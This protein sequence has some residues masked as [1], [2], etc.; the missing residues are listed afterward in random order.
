LVDARLPDRWLLNATLRDLS[1]TEW[2][3]FTG[4]LML[5]NNQLTDGLIRNNALALTHPLGLQPECYE[6]L[7][8][9]GL[10]VKVEG[11]YQVVEWEETQTL[12]ATFESQKQNNR[13]RQ[14]IKRERDAAKLNPNRAPLVTRDVTRDVQGDA[15]KGKDRQRE[16]ESSPIARPTQGR[17]Y[18]NYEVRIDPATGEEFE[19]F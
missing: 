19:V 10:W 15:R 2:R 3:V 18:P 16:E 1:D 12:K 14:R 8:S 7:V 5:A 17:S 11:G 4:S 6:R 13:E 9:V